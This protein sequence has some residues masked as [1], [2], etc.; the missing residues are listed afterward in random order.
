MN[1]AYT[2]SHEHTFEGYYYIRKAAERREGRKVIRYCEAEKRRGLIVTFNGTPVIIA[3]EERA[4]LGGW[5]ATEIQTG[6]A[7][8]DAMNTREEAITAAMNRIPT[9]ERMM[10]LYK[11]AIEQF[12]NEIQEYERAARRAAMN[13]KEAIA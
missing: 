12:E 8:T 11:P 4:E 7:V 2:V 1:A 13:A 10:I 5:V 9:I 6:T 3:V